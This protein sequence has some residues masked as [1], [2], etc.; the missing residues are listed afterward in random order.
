VFDCAAGKTTTPP[1][2]FPAGRDTLMPE[3]ATVDVRRFA[4]QRRQLRRLHNL[5]QENP[6]L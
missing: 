5:T 3:H 2:S 4:T 6:G 1:S